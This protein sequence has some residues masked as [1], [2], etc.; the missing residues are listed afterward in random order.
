MYSDFCIKFF[1]KDFFSN[2][3]LFQLDDFAVVLDLFFKFNV[4]RIN[5]TV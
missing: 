1:S 4:Y 3:H 5:F 2:V